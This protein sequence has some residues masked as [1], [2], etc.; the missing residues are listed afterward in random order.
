MIY[1]AYSKT[2]KRGRVEM[3]A[4]GRRLLGFLL[5]ETGEDIH[6]EL[7]KD[8]NGRP[9]I[10]GRKDLD[11]NISHSN[12][13]VACALSIGSGRVGIDTEPVMPTIPDDRRKK[14]AE[15]YFSRGELEL[16]MKEPH[17]FSKIWTGKEAVLKRSG[18][19]LSVGL[20]A[21][22]TTALPKKL[23]LVFLEREGHFIALC[24]D[25]EAEIKI[26]M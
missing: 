9:Y 5:E 4:E 3:S 10:K 24:A 15:R 13:M 6:V 19:G 16:L 1:L 20:S 22:D 23:K 11:F 18:A 8:K 14:F 7:L 25:S 21:V 12:D 26:V 17:S 2:N